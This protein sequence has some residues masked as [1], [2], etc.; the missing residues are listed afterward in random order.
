MSLR[1]SETLRP[2]TESRSSNPHGV[3]RSRGAGRRQ[4]L[5]EQR[6]GIP[7][8]DVRGVLTFTLAQDSK[9]YF[10]S[11]AL[12]GGE[13]EVFF[14]TE[15]RMLTIRDMRPRAD[16]LSLDREGFVLRR[17][18]SRVR[19]FFDDA[20]MKRIYAREIEELL[21]ST[22]GADRVWVFDYTRRSDAPSG[23]DNPEGARG[24]A[25]RVHVDYTANSG[26]KRARDV[27]GAEEFERITRDGGRIAQ[28]NVW[29]PI[30]GSV[31]RS[32]LALADAASVRPEE[33]IATDQIFPDR[34]GEIYQV[35]WGA[36]QRWYWA[37]EMEPDEVLLIKSWDS[38]EDGRA[39]FAPHGAFVL[40]NQSA[41]NTPRI[42][43]EVRTYAA[44]QA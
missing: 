37:P 22:T 16:R 39:R 19:D 18:E 30:A 1:A 21:K 43:I 44:F 28:I 5:D 6:A 38:A 35:A 31:Q 34:V 24:P 7:E 33:L 8:H 10:K 9:P 25:G 40:P 3:W 36:D 15:A 42:S 32:P 14:E 12:T 4:D 26:P 2:N 29:R 41:V 23:A 27:L 17:H 20:A 13:P 11:A